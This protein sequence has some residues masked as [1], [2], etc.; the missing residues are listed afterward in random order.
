MIRLPQFFEQKNSQ[1][2]NLY[3]LFMLR[4]FLITAA[5]LFITFASFK[6]IALPL[7][8]ISVTLGVLLL[9]NIITGWWLY[10]K[11]PVTDNTLILQLIIDV[12]AFTS[13][14]YFTGGASNPFGW[15]YLVPI[16]I[17]ATLL[18][19]KAIWLLTGL[20]M[21]GYTL[22]MFFYKPINEE[23]PHA[24]HMQ[25]DSGFHEHIIGMWLGYMVT[26]F[27]VAYVVA[28]MAN[29][30]RERDRD[31]AL[32]RE[33]ALRDERLV[34]L[35]TLAAGTA[36]ELGTPLS[37]IAILVKE[38]QA[39]DN[40]KQSNDYLKIIRQ[41]VDRCKAALTTLSQSAGEEL[42]S[43]GKMQTAQQYISEIIN[44]WQ[45]QRPN[46]ELE[47]LGDLNNIKARVLA[48]QTM[49][50]ALINI[51]NNAADASPEKIT[52]KAEQ[53]GEQ[54]IITVMDNG[55]G[56]DSMIQTHA[57]KKTYTSK[58]QGLGLGLFLAHA[59]IERLGGEI[60]LSNREQ[61]GASVRVI[62]PLTESDI[63]NTNDQK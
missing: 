3:R 58:E 48:E 29:S 35:G 61:G 49:T 37:T 16:F 8:S 31:L 30:L 45:Q 59:S 47:L 18:P 13:I 4:N 19:G 42:I 60:Y 44:Q 38:I 20:S 33:N 57:G 9:I 5:F 7:V 43:G 52:L 40:N 17:A 54:I 50:Q 56:L 62:L 6:D 46:T 21:V 51:L 53:H 39:I 10:S 12:A 25:H 26:A 32:A 11:N 23:N 1:A 63:D 2:H 27:L 34:A 15:F 28:R 41:Q 22:L 24:M 55:S 36:H 14:L